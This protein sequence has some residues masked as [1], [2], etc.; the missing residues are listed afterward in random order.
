MNFKK[1]KKERKATDLEK[2]H[3]LYLRISI[4]HMYFKISTD[5]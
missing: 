3:S 4:N 5:V 2:I 1:E